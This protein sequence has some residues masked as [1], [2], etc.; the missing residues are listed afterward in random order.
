VAG[1]K[2]GII[3]AGTAGAATA[4]FLARAGH[5]VTV[6][7]RVLAPGPVGAGIVVQPTG[8]AVLARLGLLDEILAHGARLDRLWCRTSGGRTLVNLRYAAIEPRWFGLGLHRGALFA[9]LYRAARAQAGV[10]IETG[11]DVRGLRR[12][13]ARVYATVADGSARGPFELLVVAD[14][15][16]SEL[17]GAAGLTARDRPYPWG[18]L[19]FVADDP[20]RVFA[21]ELYQVATRARRLYGALPTGQAP[22]RATPVVSLFWSM[23]GDRVE[24]WRA[25]GLG[26]W[27][28]EVAAMDPRMAP[29]LDQI[30]DDKQVL[31]ARYRD[32]VMSRW[33]DDAV[34]FIGDAAHATSPQLGQGANLA[35]CDAAALADPVAATGVVGDALVG[36]AD[37]RRRHL[38][39]YQRMT[40]WLT[41][42]FQSDSRLLGWT[43]D[44]L[45][46]LG[47]LLP[48]VR[49]LMIRTMAG[50]KRGF[51]RTSLQLPAGPAPG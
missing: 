47:N 30:R 43:R 23:R 21:G 5:E 8:Q 41:P 40:R 37:A 35:L 39:Y 4:L 14:G 29:F 46:P 9:T 33:H 34:V 49:G 13:G 22:G 3:G 25:A 45:F 10:T 51:V 24:A 31:F 2:V 6:L 17:R 27:K 19:W 26:P 50:V 1:V 36:Y 42:F 18:A 11:C 44:W 28:A 32:I 15:A 48:P 7:E 38:A 16:V 20:E 12:D